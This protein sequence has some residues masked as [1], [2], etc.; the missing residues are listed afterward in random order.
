MAGPFFD[1]NVLVYL[2]SGDQAKAGISAGLLRDG[3][4]IS[5]QSLNE[6]SSI[7]RRKLAMSWGDLATAIDGFA[8][9]CD[10]VPVT[11]ATNREAREL[12][13]RHGWHIYDALIVATALESGARI[14]YTEDLHSGQRIGQLQ[15]RNPFGN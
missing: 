14:L 12:A 11:L 10:V 4:T 13:R 5:A 7:A 2:F 3:G 6:F 1:T 9:L 15:I 8:G